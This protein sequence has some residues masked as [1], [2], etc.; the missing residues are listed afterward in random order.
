MH[1][2][3]HVIQASGI[4]LFLPYRMSHSITIADIPAHF[5]QVGTFPLIGQI[6]SV[7]QRMHCSGTAGVFPL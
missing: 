3:V 7:V 5:I 1:I 6:Q 4:R 2:P